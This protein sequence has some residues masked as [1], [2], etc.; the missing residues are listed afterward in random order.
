MADNNA[1]EI[2]TQ[3]NQD[4]SKN[5]MENKHID[6]ENQQSL[7]ELMQSFENKHLF[8]Q[9]VICAFLVILVLLVLSVLPNTFRTLKLA[10]ETLNN[11]NTTVV[12]A[13]KAMIQVKE[14][15]SDVSGLV[16]NSEEQIGTAMEKM[17]S[18]DFEKLNSAIGDLQAVVEPMANFFGRFR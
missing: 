11:A 8:Y 18:I 13:N 9:R 1:M 2:N 6:V 3:V 17:N 10:Q 12:N 7:I 14:T 16:K 4:V 5:A 15:L